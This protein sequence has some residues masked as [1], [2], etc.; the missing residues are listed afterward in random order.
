VSQLHQLRG[1]VGRGTAP[2][3][4]L[5]VTEAGEESPAR[6]RLAAVAATQDGFEL[7]ELDLEQRREGDVLGAAQSGRRSHL[8]LLSLLRD[9]D[10]IGEA[11]AE[12]QAL[13]DADPELEGH[14]ALRDWIAALVDEERAEFL[15]KG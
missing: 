9:R 10:L 11:R 5:L 3:L 7:A 12:A 2:G 6:E 14:P 8:R 15:E 4:C 1:R 13:L